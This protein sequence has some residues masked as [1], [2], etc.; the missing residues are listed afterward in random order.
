MNKRIISSSPSNL[1]AIAQ[2]HRKA[3]KNSLASALGTRYCSR[4]LSWYLSTD[5]TFLFHLEDDK[6]VCLA[7]CGGMRNDGA[8]PMGSSSGMAQHSFN[9]ALS[10]ILFRPWV[11]LHPELKQ[12][13]PLLWKNVKIKLFRK[14]ESEKD[15]KIN[16]K[17]EPYVGLVVIGVSPDFQGLG[18]GSKLLKEFERIST[19]LYGINRM[20]LTVLKDNK[21]AISMYSDNG[22]IVMKSSDKKWLKMSKNIE[23]TRD[24]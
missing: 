23:D 1:Y 20:H 21:K 8:V 13:W 22:W 6:G 11:L 12:K 9:R 18:I 4:M 17:I 14:K 10:A 5:Y 16:K 15:I 19:E 7:Y 2:C 24:I 3:F